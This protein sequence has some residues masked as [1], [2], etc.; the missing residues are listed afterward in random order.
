MKAWVILPVA[1][2][3]ITAGAWLT[4]R[5]RPAPVKAEPLTVPGEAGPHVTVEVLNTIGVDGLAGKVTAKLRHSGLD[6]VS[7]GSGGG[8]ARTTTEILVRRG[9][10]TPGVRVRNALGVGRVRM[11]PDANLLLDVSVL[12]G[13]DAV[14][15]LKIHP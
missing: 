15:A 5:H 6:V 14:A 12:V 8:D 1:L 13:A 4:L 9:D 10:S 2:A 7:F 11:V 3:A